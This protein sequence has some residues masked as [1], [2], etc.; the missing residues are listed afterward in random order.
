MLQRDQDRR[1]IPMIVFFF[2][3]Y[4][5][6]SIFT[7]PIFVLFTF[8]VISCKSERPEAF[9]PFGFFRLCSEMFGDRNKINIQCKFAFGEIDYIPH[10]INRSI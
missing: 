3:F 2:F 6:S 5:F 7:R 1:D 9:D 4:D 10:K 8:N